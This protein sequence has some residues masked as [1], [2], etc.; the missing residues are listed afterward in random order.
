VSFTL[1]PMMELRSVAI[2]KLK[3]LFAMVNGIKHT[4]VADIVDYF[5]DCHESWVFGNG[6]L[7][8][9]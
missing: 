9:H 8:L 2:P 3:C 5:S 7:G 4:P 1:F 6:Q